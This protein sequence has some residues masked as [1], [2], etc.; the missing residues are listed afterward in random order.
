M[1]TGGPGGLY[2]SAAYLPLQ[3]SS[4]GIALEAG[5]LG[6]GLTEFQYGICAADFPHMITG[7]YHQAIPRYISTNEDG[8]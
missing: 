5:A 1:A 6:A 3:L 8:L 7:A 2:R 4:L